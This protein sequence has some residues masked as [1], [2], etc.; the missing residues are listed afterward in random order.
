M[1]RC[2]GSADAASRCSAAVFA[3]FPHWLRAALSACRRNGRVLPIYPRKRA[4]R[5][6]S[7]KMAAAGDAK[8]LVWERGLWRVVATYAS[9]REVSLGRLLKDSDDNGKTKPTS[10]FRIAVSGSSA[11]SQMRS[12]QS[13]V[14]IYDGKTKE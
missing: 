10:N 3:Q 9:L 7:S 2:P 6:F 12:S 14:F 4:A 8:L 13:S 1:L 5:T 11:H